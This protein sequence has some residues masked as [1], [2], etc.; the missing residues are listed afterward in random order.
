[1]RAAKSARWRF[2][3]TNSGHLSPSRSPTAAPRRCA[4][5]RPSSTAPSP[6]WLV[7]AEP[8][9]LPSWPDHRVPLNHGA[10]P[11]TRQPL[12]AFQLPMRAHRP[13]THAFYP[14]LTLVLRLVASHLTFVTVPRR[15]LAADDGSSVHAFDLELP[16]VLGRPMLLLDTG[17]HR[18]L[19]DRVAWA[20]RPHGPPARRA[21]P[22][23]QLLKAAGVEGGRTC[24]RLPFADGARTVGAAL[25]CHAALRCCM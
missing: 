6:K 18:F 3:H 4:S 10:I 24:F 25:A 22:A 19:C 5:A 13:H 8:Q 11:G 9:L 2:A 20:C 15:V 7:A 23:R 12:P 21:R 16:I 14:Y 1:M 17:K